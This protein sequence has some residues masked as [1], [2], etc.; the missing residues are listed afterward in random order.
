MTAP[1]ASAVSS[2]NP[3]AAARA[4][5]K[6]LLVE[7]NPGDALLIRVMLAKV[8]GSQMT[9]ERTDRLS[10]ALKRLEQ[11]G[12]NAVLLDLSLPDSQG[13]ETFNRI[14]ERIP[15]IPILILTGH[16]D[17]GVAIRAVHL[18]AQDYLL[19]G[20][21]DGPVL[22]RALLH[23]LERKRILEA[24]RENEQRY[25][26][27]IETTSD[28]IYTVTLQN[29]VAGTTT[30]GPGCVA[31]TGYRPDDYAR[32]STLWHRMI[33]E[34]DR[35][36][37]LEDAA[38]AI[39]GVPTVPV[40]HRILHK[41]GLLRWVKH[42]S[43]S[44]RNE[45]GE[46]I[47]V[48][49]IISDIT[50]RRAAEI[51]L[52]NSEALYQ[53]LV[54]SLPQN[55]FRKD[56]RGVF[57]F[58]NSGFCKELGKTAAEIL[59][60]TD[61]DFFPLEL[62]TRYRADDERVMASQ[63]LFESVEEHV[64]PDGQRLYVQIVKIPLRDSSERVIGIQG[65]FWDVT[66]QKRNEEELRRAADALRTANAE[67]KSAQMQLIQAE[68]MLSVAGLAAGVAHEVKNPLAVLSLGVEFLTHQPFAKQGDFEL[69][70]KDMTDAIERANLV[71]G[72]LLDFSR[73]KELE[74][75]SESVTAVAERALKLISH[76][77]SNRSIEIIRQFQND[78][79]AIHVDRVKIEQVF[80][81]LFTNALHAMPRFGTLSVR[82]YQKILAEDEAE[83]N[84]GL[85][86]WDRIRTGDRVVVFEID[87]TGSGIP[88]DKLS[89]VFDPFYTTKPTN[90]GTGLGLS[91]VSK[92]L[93][94][95]SA[96][97]SIRNRPEGGVRVKL[98]FRAPPT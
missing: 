2:P 35:A 80:V 44:R 59:G 87:D 96:M 64:T 65:I 60:R 19:K 45:R 41:D 77:F 66:A 95:H 25:K 40:E 74:L 8:G 42:T 69:V 47:A 61:F 90:E 17:E 86:G 39:A 97:I 91:V 10:E 13:L 93:E 7:D 27:L 30:H 58:V 73:E 62:A 67:L 36:A 72:G 20:Q 51:R 22:L 81:N 26:L 54:E 55:I 33:H 1:S 83:L 94:L 24:L 98:F 38:R 23:A 70:L 84:P 28:Y 50:E 14:Y 88:D 37:V 15:Q 79:P 68:K 43:V 49:G 34:D 16:D 21:V 53:S 82:A 3:P 9:L 85:R 52:R 78:L 63:K 5:L 48:E 4:P 92:I 46:V 12:I 75:T 29:G 89:R 71:I 31:V 18:G 76:L 32:D 57:T 6:I 11:G 56:L